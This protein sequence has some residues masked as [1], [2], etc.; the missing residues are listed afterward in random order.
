MS[1][2]QL[3]AWR[4][5]GERIVFTNGVFDILHAGHVMYLAEAKSRGE[6]LVV[7]LNSD[8]SVRTLGKGPERPINPE[9][10]RKAVLEGLRAVDMVVIFEEP[11]PERLIEQIRPDVLVKGGDYAAAC[12][13]SNHPA[14]IVG[15]EGVRERGGVV[16]VIPLLP[17]RSTTNIIKKSRQ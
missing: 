12:S 5:A 2:V 6:R 10:D 11:T 14:F 15:S 1:E 4:K 17:G 9:A 16:E 8:E 7:G 3:A 13:D